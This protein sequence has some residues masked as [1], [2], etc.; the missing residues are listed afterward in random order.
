MNAVVSNLNEKFNAG[1]ITEHEFC[2][3]VVNYV[4]TITNGAEYEFALV[5]ILES[6][7]QIP[8]SVGGLAKGVVGIPDTLN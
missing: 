4:R 8:Y 6:K 5:D 1:E 7:G 2:D 3:G